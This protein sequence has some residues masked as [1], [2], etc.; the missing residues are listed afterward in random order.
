MKQSHLKPSRLDVWGNH[1]LCGQKSL[2]RKRRLREAS[3]KR[4]VAT[5]KE[6]NEI[7]EGSRLSCL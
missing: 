4:R 3:K 7:P 6:L 5:K 1:M 2:T